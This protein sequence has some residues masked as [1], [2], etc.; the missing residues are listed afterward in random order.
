MPEALG[1]FG[2]NPLAS[3]KQEVLQTLRQLEGPVA[4][5]HLGGMFHRDA[6]GTEIHE[7]INDLIASKQVHRLSGASGRAYV[8]ATISLEDTEDAMLKLLSED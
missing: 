7:V 2:L 8:Q 6:R 4:M 5:S 3:L 1:E